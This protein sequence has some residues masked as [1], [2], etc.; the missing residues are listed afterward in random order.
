[1]WKGEIQ[2]K[3]LN[4]LS[5]RGKT[6]KRKINEISN[7]YTVHTVPGFET[8][9]NDI[10]IVMQRKQ[11]DNLDTIEAEIVSFKEITK[12]RNA[13]RIVPPL[14]FDEQLS[15]DKHEGDEQDEDRKY[16]PLRI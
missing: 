5:Y 13:S 15:I 10:A 6:K 1:M 8:L 14:E 2:V 12:G 16:F 11:V 7:T 4:N 9:K 3:C